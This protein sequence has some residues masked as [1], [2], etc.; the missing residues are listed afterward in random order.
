MSTGDVCLPVCPSPPPPSVNEKTRRKTRSIPYTRLP[1]PQLLTSTI[2]LEKCTNTIHPFGAPTSRSFSLPTTA[3]CQLRLL[4]PPL[5]RPRFLVVAVAASPFTPMKEEAAEKSDK[6]RCCN[7]GRSCGGL[8]AT[9]AP[10]PPLPPPSVE[11]A[12]RRATW[13]GGCSWAWP[14]GRGRVAAGHTRFLLL[15]SLTPQLGDI[16]NLSQQPP[17]A[18]LKSKWHRRS[19]NLSRM[20]T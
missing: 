15:I 8:V 7:G 3:Q 11:E 5:P 1:F 20:C 13:L 2:L 19:Y 10:S 14:S 9:G 17:L 6:A 16:F 12:Q 18:S 4:S